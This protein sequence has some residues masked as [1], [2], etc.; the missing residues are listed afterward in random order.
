MRAAQTLPRG[1]APVWRRKQ[2]KRLRPARSSERVYSMGPVLLCAAAFLVGYLPGILAGRGGETVLGQQLADYYMDTGHF[3]SWSSAFA[4]QMAS[5]FV[6]LFLLT[7]CGFSAL[8]TGALVLFF[9]AKGIFMGFC[10]ANL[11]ALGGG[12]ALLIYWTL[13][14]LPNIVLLFWELW[15][16][17][18]AAQLSH[19]LFQSIFLGGAPRGQ[20]EAAARRMGVRCCVALLASGIFHALCSGVSVLVLRVF[21]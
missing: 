21:G 5:S 4:N 2:E 1:K 9:A 18:Y 6:Q 11:V 17:G 14:C 12:R 20:L 3:S 15:L 13:S 16:A 19:G 7:L 8:G 10:A